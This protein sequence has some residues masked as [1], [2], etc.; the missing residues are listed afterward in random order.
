MTDGSQLDSIFPLFS[1]CKPF[2]P[3]LHTVQGARTYKVRTTPQSSIRSPLRSAGP[4]ENARESSFSR[5]EA[6]RPAT[7]APR[8][9]AGFARD[10]PL[11]LGNPTPG[12]PEDKVADE[13]LDVRRA[14]RRG[15]YEKP[16][17]GRRRDD[18]CV[19]KKAWWW[20]ANQTGLAVRRGQFARDGA[21]R[22]ERKPR[23]A[24]Q[25]GPTLVRWERVRGAPNKTT[26]QRCCRIGASPHRPA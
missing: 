4:T 5:D 13:M 20:S 17:E 15:D 7:T 21:S 11:P 14:R 6:P 16:M 26:G 19:A 10:L 22:I 8:T 1:F 25:P 9:R 2:K 12:R 3:F 18:A 23:R 24:R